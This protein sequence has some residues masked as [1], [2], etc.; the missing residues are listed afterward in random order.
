MADN[1][2][3]KEKEVELGAFWKYTG[4]KGDYFLGK[5]I[6]D[7]VT[8]EVILFTNTEKINPK[9]PDLRMYKSKPRNV[10]PAPTTQAKPAAAK[11]AA[12]AI[13]AKKPVARPPVVQQQ[14]EED[15][16]PQNM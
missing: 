16:L 1:N 4:A 12:S 6:I 15:D 11:P 7:G 8:T 9:S 3:A 10:A 2:T 5:V 14:E 13:P